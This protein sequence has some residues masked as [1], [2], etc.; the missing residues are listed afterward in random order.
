MMKQTWN[1][2][3]TGFVA[4]GGLVGW[5]LGGFDASLYTLLAFVMVDYITGVLRA[6][7]EKKVSSRIG[8]KGITKKILIF[9]LVGVGHMLDLELKT[10]NVLRDAVIFFYISNEG[11]SLLENAVSIGLPLPEKVK[12]ALKQ[13]HGKEDNENGN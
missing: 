6:I 11:I 3:Q 8:A 9:L 5:Y 10:G 13:L 1:L 2:I 12:E 4:T 7:N